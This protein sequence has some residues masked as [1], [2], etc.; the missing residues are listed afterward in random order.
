[1]GAPVPPVC[2]FRDRDGNRFTWSSSGA[3]PVR[4]AAA[5]QRAA[6]CE[7]AAARCAMMRA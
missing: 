4:W 1:M 2:F 7:V 6:A 3:D 5:P